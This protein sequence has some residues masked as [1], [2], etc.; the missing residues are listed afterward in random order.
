LF[1]YVQVTVHFLQAQ[2]LTSLVVD[3]L[4]NSLIIGA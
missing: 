4:I 3:R 2:F 1:G